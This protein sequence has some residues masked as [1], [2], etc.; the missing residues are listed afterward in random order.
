MCTEQR[1]QM[2]QMF[3]NMDPSMFANM[4]KSMGMPQVSEEQIKEV[5][6]KLI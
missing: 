5:W 6:E 4:A 1:A 2:G 3:S